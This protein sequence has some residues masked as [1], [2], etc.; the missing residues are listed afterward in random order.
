MADSLEKN[1]QVEPGFELPQNTSVINTEGREVFE[2]KKWPNLQFVISQL[3]SLVVPVADMSKL[4]SGFYSMAVIEHKNYSSGKDGLNESKSNAIF[5]D[6]IFRDWDHDVF[7]KN[8]DNGI[9]YDFHVGDLK[10]SSMGV[11]Q[12]YTLGDDLE[13]WKTVIDILIKKILYFK[14]QVEGESGLSFLKALLE[15][16]GKGDCTPND[17]IKLQ[18]ILI[19]RCDRGIAILSK[20]SSK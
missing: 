12:L 11:E 15:K 6:M 17:E 19:S 1:I 4:D 13:G 2:I 20:H 8:V 3:A 5:L 10:D 7:D 14:S 16:A 9:F 18:K